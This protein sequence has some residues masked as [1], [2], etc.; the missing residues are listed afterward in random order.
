M[1]DD[2]RQLN[3]IAVTL[4]VIAV[5]FL[6]WAAV[7]WVTRLPAFDYREVVVTTPLARASG[8]HLEAVIRGE[9]R[10]TFFTMDLDAARASLGAR[11]V[12][13]RRRAAP[14]MA[15]TARDRGRRAR[16]ARALERQRARQHARRRVHRELG[17]RT[18]ASSAGRTDSRGVMVAALSRVGRAARAARAARCRPAPVRRAAAGKLQTRDGNGALTLDVGRDD[19]AGGSRASSPCMRGR[20]G[21]LAR[22]GKP[23]RSRRS[24]LSQRLRRAHAGIPRKAAAEGV[25]T[26]VASN[27]VVALCSAA[28]VRAQCHQE[29]GQGKREGQQQP[30][31]RPRHRHVE[32]RRDRRRG[33]ARR[34]TQHRRPRHAAVARPEEGRR[35]QHR[36]DDG[37]DPARARG[38]RADG[39]LPDQRGLHRHRRQPHPQ[40]QLERHGRDQGKGSH[41][42]RHRPRRRDGEGDR[43]PERPAGAAHPAAGIHH[44]RPGRRARAARHERRAARGEGAHRHRRRVGRREH[45]QVRAPLRP[46]SARR[47]AAAARVGE[48]GAERRREGPRRVPDGHRRRHDRHRRVRRRR[49]PPHRGDSDRRR[50][51]DQ[52]HRD[53]AAHADEGG[54][55]AQGP[56]RLRAAAARRIPT[57]SSKCPAS[58]SARRAS[59]R[60]RCSPK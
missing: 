10:G 50:P 44:R 4:T 31:R 54:R 42:G 32:D 60:G 25:M 47:D 19:V 39:R 26:D 11:A 3:A 17:R 7:G 23:R 13:A 2:A 43:D 59:C 15:A 53:D 35:R 20:V 52:R 28:R 49:D 51:G 41:A 30:D 58:A 27:V 56:P 1:W 55:G 57:R 16:A 45:H 18:A 29:A 34:R 38:S 21:V 5:A 46:R 40:P 8:A 9:L 6:A 36:G 37:V 24:A 22:A 33:A 48:G 14:A 12:G